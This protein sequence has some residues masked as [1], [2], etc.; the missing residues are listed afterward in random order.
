MRLEGIG[1]KF[2]GW[3]I[4]YARVRTCVSFQEPTEKLGWVAHAFV[5]PALGKWREKD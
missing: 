2:C 5:I 3:S 1:R 4:C